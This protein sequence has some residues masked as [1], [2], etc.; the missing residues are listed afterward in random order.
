M[1]WIDG[2]PVIGKPGPDGIG[3]MVWGGDRPIPAKSKSEL[4]ASDSLRKRF[5]L[6]EWEWRYQ[7]RPD[8]WR[9]TGRGLRMQALLPLA[10]KSEFAGVRNVLTQ[11]SARTAK[12]EVTVTMDLG[13]LVNGEEAGLAHFAREIAGL[14]LFRLEE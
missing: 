8:A 4:F 1:T 9:L 11:R 14:R 12:A 7:P 5:L 3:K 6:P 2:W 13:G 10:G